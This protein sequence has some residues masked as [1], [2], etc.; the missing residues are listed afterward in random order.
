MLDVITIG[1]AVRDVFLVSKAFMLI[2]L[3]EL[4]GNFAECVALGSKIDVETLVIT[5][6]GGATNAAVTFRRLGFKTAAISRVGDDD[7]G[8]SIIDELKNEKIETDLIKKI[9]NGQT[10]YSTILTAV[11][12]ERT[13]LTY[14]GVSHGW[15]ESDIPAA[16]I[17]AGWLYITSLGGN[18]PPL[19]AAL[20]HAKIRT[21]AVAWNPGNAELKLGLRALDP[22]LRQVH[23]LLLNLEEAQQLTGLQTTDVKEIAAKLTR[24]GMTILLT[25][26]T[27][28][29]HAFQDGHHWHAGTRSVRSVSRTGAGDAFGSGFVAAK[30]R[31]LEIADALRV[32][33]LNAESVI[34]QFGAKAGILRAWP[35]KKQMSD[36]PISTLS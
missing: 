6:G 21:M 15:K 35:T 2:P 11:N 34:G 8:L 16:K 20:R 9:K 28:G 1:A 32:A 7:A 31:G 4:G 29:T 36:V 5:S 17:K 3:P 13:I 33:T 30:M 25:D 22:I 24:P 26:G 27:N 14:R 19:I 12:G 18:M 23:V 10:A